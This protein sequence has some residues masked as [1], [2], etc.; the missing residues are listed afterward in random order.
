MPFGSRI[1]IA[2]AVALFAQPVSAQT[3]I[4]FICPTLDRNSGELLVLV[5]TGCITG[6][7][8]YKDDDLHLEVDQQNA[9]IRVNGS[10][11][12][13]PLDSMIVTQDC[14]GAK[15]VTLTASGMAA[16]RYTVLFNGDRLGTADLLEQSQPN[17][18]MSAARHRRVSSFAVVN[19]QMFDDWSSNPIDG[20]QE[21]RAPD[22]FEL[23]APLLANHPETMKGHPQ[24]ELKIE[25]RVWNMAGTRTDKPWKSYPFVA[26]WLTRHGFLDDSVSGDRYFAE[27]RHNG[28]GWL[29]EALFGQN[30][31]ARGEAAGQWTAEPCP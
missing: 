22:V 21:L 27:L 11:N 8:R 23:L 13:H 25:K 31:C 10:I 3:N 15:Q 4:S 20:W 30:M 1:W 14:G 2:A 6:M 29:I 19:R 17:S 12:Y 16:R 7:A 18:C 28:D 24:V 9:V 26:V 5:D